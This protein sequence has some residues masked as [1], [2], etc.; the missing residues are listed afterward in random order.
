MAVP[1]LKQL[2]LAALPVG[3]VLVIAPAG[4][5]K[6][7]ALAL[8]TA[9]VIE[10][11]EVTAPR[12]V[13]A[14]T[15]SNKAKANLAVRMQS[16]VGSGWRRR[17]TVT[18]FHGLAARI[19]QAH[20]EVVGIPSDVKL[21]EARWRRGALR[22][23]GIGYK[24]SSAFDEALAAAKGGLFDDD[25][26]LQRL[27]Q[28]GHARALAFEQQLRDDNRLDYDD[29]I[30]H[31]ARLLAVPSVARLYQQHFGMV[32]VDEAQDLSMMQYGLVTAIG[33]DRITFAGDP[34]QGI[35]SFTGAD[36]DAVFAAIKVTAPSTV[37]F[38]QSYRSA[39]AVLTAVNALAA[40]MDST[41]LHCA[42]PDRWGDG[43]RVISITA[44]NRDE[45]AA[46]V[47]DLVFEVT[48]DP[49]ATIGIVFRSGAR[50]SR[51][52]EAAR[53]AGVSFE[54]WTLATHMPKVVELL[55]KTYP[56]ASKLGAGDPD[57]L[58]HL[59]DMC[60]NELAPDDAETHD[61]LSNAIGQL[62]EAV[63]EG[64]SLAD[65]MAGCRVSADPDAAV[66]AGLHLLTGHKGKGQ[67]FD[68]VVV[69]G[70]EV[71][72][73]PHW[74]SEGPEEVDEELRVLHVMASRARYGLAFTFCETETK[75]GRQHPTAKSDWLEILE[76]AATEYR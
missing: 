59:E 71:G 30:R 42:D 5:G 48:A 63:D 53:A 22:K 36:P 34:A 54:D 1:N 75:W 31:A 69:L 56:L 72:Q 8:R 61:E 62:A 18:N 49:C 29:L 47:L 32:I 4:C 6:T 65:A 76:G 7:E 44:P 43:G 57:V 52:R 55:R 60:R 39:P 68:W 67:E 64:T 20:G 50:A 38:D 23:L 17:V 35:Y 25:E 10:R 12:R 70:L 14:L 51:L 41:Q 13:L 26:V 74:M 21:P 3:P 46:A 24:E 40:E 28:T 73:V 45:E 33:E 27:A 37:E 15:F 9:A 16:C 58:D 2:D 66:A 11:R 19:V